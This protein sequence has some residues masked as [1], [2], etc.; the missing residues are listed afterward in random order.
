MT[1]REYLYG[2][3]ALIFLGFAGACFVRL[4]KNHEQRVGVKWATVSLMFLFASF[5]V[6]FG[7]RIDS[8]ELMRHGSSDRANVLL[9]SLGHNIALAAIVISA[10]GIYF[11]LHQP[12]SGGPD[13]RKGD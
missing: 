7:Y 5:V 2:A 11:A 12:P 3:I 4:L 13:D 8:A 10:L 9:D 1:P 6:D